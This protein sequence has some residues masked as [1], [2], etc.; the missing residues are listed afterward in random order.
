MQPKLI[1]GAC[2]QCARPFKFYGSRPR[3][4]CSRDCFFASQDAEARFWG[5]VNKTPDGCWLWTGTLLTTGY[6]RLMVKGKPVN[7]HRY[8]YRLHYGEIEDDLNVCHRCD[9]RHCVNPAHLW[10]G[11]DTQNMQDMSAKGRAASGARSSAHL[12]QHCRK[13][14]LTA[15]DI[16]GIRKLCAEGVNQRLIAKRYGVKPNSISNIHRRVS[17][18]HVK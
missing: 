14:N 10:L 5:R 1:T 15:A 2:A 16:P 9:V 4:Y 12:H 17:W 8:S 18:A 3:L 7:V 11:T 6:G 13:S